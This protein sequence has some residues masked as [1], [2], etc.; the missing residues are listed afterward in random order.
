MRR[1]LLLM[2][3]AGLLAAPAPAGAAVYDDNPAAA[4]RSP[5]DV[6]V[7]AR[8]ADGAVLERHL[9]G[10]GWTSWASLGGG[11]ISGPAAA[12]YGATVSVFVVGGD[13]A[14]YQNTL[15]QGAWSGW[16]SL[17]GVATSA[18]A[19]VARRGTSVLDLAVRGT[20]GAV[21]HKW[22]AP[23]QGW[24]GWESLG[25]YVTAAP[26]LNSQINGQLNVFA[27][28]GDD[29]VYQR[30]WDGSQWS[31]WFSLG[32]VATSAV[33]SVTQTYG[34][35]DLYVRGADRALYQQNWSGSAWSGWLMV[36]PGPIDSG[37]GA[38][39]DQSGHETVFAR[40][41]DQLSYKAFAGS[42]GSLTAWGPVAVPAPPPPPQPPPPPDGEVNLE[43]GVRCTPPGGRLR[44]HITI[45]R[46]KGA[47]RPRVQK[48]VFFTR[49][50]GRRTRVD[51]KPPFTVHLRINR[52]AGS[53]GRVYARVYFRRSAH[54]PLHRKTVSRRYAVCR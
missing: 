2:F 31:G 39:S 10:S 45:R 51:R 38:V 19:A 25:G 3:A 1:V 7:F 30:F 8:A 32:G 12:A 43:A 5:G 23:G 49:G 20:D 24:S 29:A 16:V 44:V 35:V 27:P 36:D 4:S 48:I 26:A 37:P 6:Y 54:G 15:S 50:K 9:T 47:P 41:G 21:Y 18:P 33:S 34:T 52:S 46:R 22:Y 42:W 40:T 53:T 14:V 13:G 17:G 28:G 11:A